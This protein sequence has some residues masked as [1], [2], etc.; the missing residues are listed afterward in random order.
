MHALFICFPLIM[1][2]WKSDSYSFSS[3]RM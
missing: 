2:C 1:E 3:F